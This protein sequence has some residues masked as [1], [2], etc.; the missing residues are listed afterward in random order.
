MNRTSHTRQTGVILLNGQEIPYLWLRSSLRKRLTL[1]VTA[2]KEVEVRSPWTIG[3]QRLEAFLYAHGSWL[4]TRLEVVE[5]TMRQRPALADGALLPFLD[6]TLA[7]RMMGEEATR[8]Q[9]VEDELRIP[10]P[11]TPG[12]VESM[13]E[14]WYRKEARLYL[15]ARVQRRAQ[16]MGVSIQGVTIR[17]QKSRW[18][19]CSTRGGIS[20]NWQLMFLP[21]RVVEYVIVHELCHRRHMNHSPEFWSLVGTIL[22]DYPQLQKQLRTIQTPWRID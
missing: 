20:L 16:E 17:G 15:D 8:I 10:Q 13:L 21:S 19:S 4:L 9:R 12:G 7:I 22:P 5:E 11:L 3:V 14:R 2:D 18:G 6:A 1:R